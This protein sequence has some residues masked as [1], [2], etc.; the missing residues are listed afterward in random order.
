MAAHVNG[1][2]PKIIYLRNHASGDTS[3]PV[4]DNCDIT[5]S[6]IDGQSEFSD[7]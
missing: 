1:H 5:I 2:A 4:V 3:I 6:D 7:S